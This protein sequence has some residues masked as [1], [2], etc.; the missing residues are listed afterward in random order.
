MRILDCA[1]IRDHT[2][3][4]NP[5][6]S[7]G[8]HKQPNDEYRI[9]Y[10][11]SGIGL[12]RINGSKH[13]VRSDHLFITYPGDNY[14]ITDQ[15]AEVSFTSFLL[16][17]L[18]EEI[19]GDLTEL[20][21]ETAVKSR[22]IL[23]NRNLHF[24]FEEIVT[25]FGSKRKYANECCKHYLLGFLFSITHSSA[26]EK[27][28]S[29]S[30][31]HIETALAIMGKKVREKLTLGEL[32]K[33]LNITEPHFIRTFKSHMKISPI[34]Y[35]MR[36]K[37]DEAAL[38]L[39]ESNLLIYEIAE[40]LNF[41]SETH[42]SRTFKKF[43]FKTPANYRNSQIQSLSKHRNRSEI[44]LANANRMIQTIIDA[45]PDLIF[46]KN[47]DGVILWCNNAY[48]K[49]HGLSKEQILGRSDFEII[50]KHRAEFF[51]EKDRN[52]FIQNKAIKNEEWMTLPS[53]ERRKYEVFKAPVHDSA[54]AIIGLLGISRDI[55]KME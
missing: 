27:T 19:D 9:H 41:S 12:L 17:F 14:V 24:L 7:S 2:L 49:I 45:S 46:F 36:L 3:F 35:F 51:Q 28:S 47:T 23:S 44:N 33:E 10:V 5:G 48:E 26:E 38:L 52:I 4:S 40:C 22:Y 30:I 11:M 29:S 53:G 15:C 13:L 34:R 18:V 37:I 50:P 6:L 32:C 39:C 16:S 25:I 43:K 31:S 21:H 55:M 1:F 42:F 54:G 8:I 20:L